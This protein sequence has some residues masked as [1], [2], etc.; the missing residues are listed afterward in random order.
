MIERTLDN[1]IENALRHTP[2]QGEVR[3]ELGCDEERRSVRVTVSDT[4]T[5][6]PPAVLL[7]D[8]VHHRE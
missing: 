1:L 8:A 3:I 5:S 6:Q 4:G 2:A 7:D